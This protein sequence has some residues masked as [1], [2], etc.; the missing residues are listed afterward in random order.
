L[1]AQ[2]SSTWPFSQRR[3]RKAYF[4]D[5]AWRQNCEQGSENEIETSSEINQKIAEA[6]NSYKR[7]TGASW[8]P[9]QEEIEAFER[10]LKGVRLSGES[11]LIEVAAT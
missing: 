9:S 5:K 6:I 1:F 10:S 7:E 3:C 8:P 11:E 4:G 2:C